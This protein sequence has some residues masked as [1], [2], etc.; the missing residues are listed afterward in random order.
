MAALLL[1]G[2]L[3]HGPVHFHGDSAHVVHLLDGTSDPPDLHLY[4]CVSLAHDLLTGWPY[5]A[6]WHPRTENTICDALAR[7]A[8]AT[9]TVRLAVGEFPRRRAH[10]AHW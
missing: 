9:G 8:A 3:D 6:T 10:L 5:A 7:E 4:N 1:T 2:L